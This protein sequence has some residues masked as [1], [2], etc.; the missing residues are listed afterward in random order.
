MLGSMRTL[1]VV[2][3]LV[4]SGTAC[5]GERGE[6]AYQGTLG[7][8]MAEHIETIEN[9]GMD[10]SSIHDVDDCRAARS[11]LIERVATLRRLQRVVG[12]TDVATWKSMPQSLEERRET[13]VRK[14][15]AEGFR[16]FRDGPKAALLRDVLAEV[17]ALI[18]PEYR[19]K[20]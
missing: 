3:L 1:L 7:D 9:L 20:R 15:N 11:T 13:A 17:P 6:T 16:V 12:L 18:Y 4:F 19:D 5:L 2:S 14:F 8:A 10:L